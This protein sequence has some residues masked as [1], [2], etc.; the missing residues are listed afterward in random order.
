MKTMLMIPPQFLPVPAVRGGA[1]EELSTRLI[2]GNETSPRYGITVLSKPDDALDGVSYRYTNIVPIQAARIHRVLARIINKIVFLTHR[3]QYVTPE[4][5]KILALVLRGK[6]DVIL[7]E[8][9]MLAC[10]M[11]SGFKWFKKRVRLIY[12]MHN[13]YDGSSKTPALVRDI[14][15]HVDVFLVISEYLRS[16]VVS[17]E[18]VDMSDK[19]KVLDN[20]IDI[21]AFMQ[22]G[23]RERWRREFGI[24]SRNV[25][26]VYSGRITPEK[27][28]RELIEAYIRMADAS[29]C[30]TKLLIV[31]KSWFGTDDVDPYAEELKALSAG[32]DDIIFTGFV[33]HEDMPGVLSAADVAVIPSRW[34]E[35][36][37]L[38][39]LEAMVA[40]LAII[41]TRS[42]AIPEIVSNESAFLINNE[43]D[44]IVD[45][46]AAA[47]HTAL[48]SEKRMQKIHDAQLT[49]TQHPEYDVHGYFD[50]FCDLIDERK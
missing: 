7:V 5:L 39:V 12:H 30:S 2:E 6:H 33:Q 28:V 20:A 16:Q 22:G 32:R 23:D 8:N 37:G 10:N 9:D 18:A 46:L 38:V 11:I 40:G 34:E 13:D 49:L 29:D 24:D 1:V 44:T 27:G 19:V 21:K 42:G 14:M 45:D 31:G 3:G 15:P 50:R 43:D 25:T 17:A 35:P 48:D 4:A 47:M 41:A 36:F 26:F